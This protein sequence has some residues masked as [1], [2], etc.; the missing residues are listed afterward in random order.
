[1]PGGELRVR[2]LAE[3]RRAGTPSW[4][5]RVVDNTRDGAL[6]VLESAPSSPDGTAMTVDL[7]AA[8]GWDGTRYSG[9]RAAAPFAILDVVRDATDFV[10]AARPDTRFPPLTLHWSPNNVPS[11]GVDGKPDFA[12][13][14]IGSSLFSPLSGIFLLGAAE[15]DTDEYDRH[16]I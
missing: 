13:G 1:P 3:M 16:V 5:Y 10:L 6:F 11:R 15:S 2:A 4:E 12:S 7:H 14:E 9:V 8:S